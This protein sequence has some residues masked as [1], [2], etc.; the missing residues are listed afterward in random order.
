M[1]VLYVCTDFNRSGAA[2]AMIEL[3]CN[4][5]RNN[6]ESLLV[7]PGYGDAVEEAKSR[8]LETKVIRS[9]EWTRPINRNESTSIRIKWFL[10]YLYNIISIVKI[11]LLIKRERIDIVHNNT[12]WG[13]VGPVSA[14]ITHTKLVWHIREMLK[15][16]NVKIRWVN[17]GKRLIGKADAL[18]AI[19]KYVVDGYSKL[20]THSRLELIY[21]GV[22]REKYYLPD[23][24]LMK[25]ECLNIIT[26]GGVRPHKRQMDIVKA[27][28]IL[29]TK[30][31]NIHLRVVGDDITI[32]AKEIREY[33]QNHNLVDYVEFCGETGDVTNLYKISDVAVTASE[34]EAFGRVTVEGMLAGCVVVAS[35]SGANAELIQDKSTGL[36]YELCN[37]EEIAKDLI[38]IIEHKSE[39]SSYARN[40]QSHAFDM[41]N[42]IENARKIYEIYS[43]LV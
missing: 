3:A 5:K 37:V 18:I 23:R 2:L 27:V 43:S 42:S 38:Y 20:I 11:S 12:M 31:P 8:G 34:H 7:F 19:S 6:V 28:E 40:G 30:T 17:F 21:D 22:E 15:E 36:I 9:Y 26:V 16:Q 10:K 29:T 41:F 4:E 13:Y 1:K 39:A 25:S 32:Y 33:V 24:E 35:N 14:V